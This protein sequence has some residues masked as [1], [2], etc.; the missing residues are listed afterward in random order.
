MLLTCLRAWIFIIV[1]LKIYTSE[2]GAWLGRTGPA[3]PGSTSAFTG[4]V[5][6]VSTVEE[7]KNKVVLGYGLAEV[8][9]SIHVRTSIH[10]LIG[11]VGAVSNP[12]LCRVAVHRTLKR[13]ARNRA[14]TSV[15][16]SGDIITR[17]RYCSPRVSLH[18]V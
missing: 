3:V 11:Y 18:S 14:L 13:A 15:P 8:L 1:S 17:A 6:E 2:D 7:L 4:T 10:L 9:F 5:V 16:D 12:L